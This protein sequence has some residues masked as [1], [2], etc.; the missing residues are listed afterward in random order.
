MNQKA[1]SLP[2]KTNQIKQ[3]NFKV[4]EDFYWK[5]KNFASTKRLKMGEVLEKAFKFYEKR[6]AIINEINTYRQTISAIEQ[7]IQPFQGNM[8]WA[9]LEL[10][11][12]NLSPELFN[13]IGLIITY[14]TLKEVLR[15]C[16]RLG[17]LS[18]VAS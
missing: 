12:N 18:K 11:M 1:K 7:Q 16:L 10:R 3:L 6:E 13:R 5:L 4:P 9:E 15:E 17:K 8:S 2:Q 14:Q